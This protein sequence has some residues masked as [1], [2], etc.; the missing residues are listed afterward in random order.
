MIYPCKSGKNPPYCL[1]STVLQIGYVGTDADTNMISTKNNVSLP[2]SGED[3][4]TG[5]Q[6]YLFKF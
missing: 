4:L 3:I 1:T 2:L 5:S 6:M